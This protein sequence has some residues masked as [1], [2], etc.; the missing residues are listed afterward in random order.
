MPQEKKQV[1]KT[2]IFIDTSIETKNNDAYWSKVCRYV[3]PRDANTVIEYYSWSN[4]CVRQPIIFKQTVGSCTSLEALVNAIEC[5]Q[6]QNPDDSYVVFACNSVW[7][8]SNLSSTSASPPN[9]NL[10]VYHIVTD[11]NYKKQVDYSKSF[12]KF[13]SVLA[14]KN[15]LRAVH[16]F[17][18]DMEIELDLKELT[19]KEWR[20]EYD[21]CKTIGDFVLLRAKFFLCG[22]LE[23]K[24]SILDDMYSPLGQVQEFECSD[25]GIE[26]FLA[27]ARLRYFKDVGPFEFFDK[28]L[29]SYNSNNVKDCLSFNNKIDTGMLQLFG[30]ASRDF[31]S[32]EY[33]EVQTID[34]DSKTCIFLTCK[35]GP[36][37][38]PGMLRR[39]PV[40]FTKLVKLS[41]RFCSGEKYDSV[42]F[43]LFGQTEPDGQDC[44]DG[45]D[46]CLNDLSVNQK[47][48]RY[49]SQIKDM[50]TSDYFH[51]LVSL[52]HYLT[53]YGSKE[54]AQRIWFEIG[55]W[56]DKPC[57]VGQIL[58]SHKFE[59]FLRNKDLISKSEPVCLAFLNK[60]KRN[61]YVSPAFDEWFEAERM[62]L[63]LKVHDLPVRVNRFLIK[64]RTG[65]YVFQ[66]GGNCAISI[67]VTDEQREKYIDKIMSDSACSVSMMRE[68]CQDFSGNM[69]QH[70]MQ[71]VC[72]EFYR[73]FI[74]PSLENTDR[75]VNVKKN[76]ALDKY[77]K[78][79]EDLMRALANH[80]DAD[81]LDRPV[82]ERF[83]MVHYV[84]DPA[85]FLPVPK[86]FE[87]SS[88]DQCFTI[89]PS[90]LLD[91]N[92]LRKYLFDEFGTRP[93]ISNLRI[94][95]DFMREPGRDNF[96]LSELLKY[97]VDKISYRS[98]VIR[99]FHGI[100]M[101]QNFY[102]TGIKMTRLK[103]KYS[104]DRP[105]VV[106]SLNLSVLLETLCFY[107]QW[108]IAKNN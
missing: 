52:W 31:G 102:T 2:H 108:S 42:P 76:G 43:I 81:R 22:G 105:I 54:K 32:V 99:K 106:S 11:P 98:A 97:F 1:H 89:S 107:I 73:Y 8:P 25:K 15:G 21:A 74:L 41:Q 40:L 62:R 56:L 69:D 67:H 29:E 7:C 100:N 83:K 92:G 82:Q 3:W 87:Y 16:F 6:K 34:E 28:I 57:M 55:Y 47:S 9:K 44:Q 78:I 70:A 48:M 90:V 91:D 61:K 17:L 88:K 14:A 50:T 71:R 24:K 72:A 75:D 18:P 33:S 53:V 35:E 49:L 65:G 4:V 84:S 23:Y 27:A 96:T 93:F 10:T 20:A 36:T 38:F 86:D 59:F 64:T 95:T 85:K 94:L 68:M 60:L 51:L 30:E 45:Q 46:S 77:T 39:Y 101:Q 26:D 19:A 104:Y 103:N 37:L 79:P 5:C 12:F 63:A 80:C 66:V 13:V 58:V